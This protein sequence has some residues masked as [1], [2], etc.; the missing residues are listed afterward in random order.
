MGVSIEGSTVEAKGNRG[1]IA[2]GALTITDATVKAT[3]GGPAIFAGSSITLDGSN[4][5]AKSTG[6]S[7]I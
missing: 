1:I 6:S 7:A 4:M 3:G 5:T 2:S